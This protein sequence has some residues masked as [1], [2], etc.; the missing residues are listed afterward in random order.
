VAATADSSHAPQHGDKENCK[1]LVFLE[2]FTFNLHR[3]M[4]FSRLIL[5]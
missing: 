3:E 1:L 5:E 4:T 2:K